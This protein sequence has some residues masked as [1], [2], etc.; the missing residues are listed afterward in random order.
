MNTI[1]IAFVMLPSLDPDNIFQPPGKYFPI[2]LIFETSK[3]SKNQFLVKIKLN[4]FLNP[5]LGMLKRNRF[6][7]P[8]ILKTTHL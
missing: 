6:F 7:L 8:D 1:K 4:E 2:R 3:C 5:L